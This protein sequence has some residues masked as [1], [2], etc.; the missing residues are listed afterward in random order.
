MKTLTTSLLDVNVYKNNI[1]N[2]AENISDSAKV[3]WSGLSPNTDYWW[4]ASI[5]S[6]DGDR[7]NTELAEV[8]TRSGGGHSSQDKNETAPPVSKPDPS[9]IVIS[10]GSEI[11]SVT[12]EM[13]GT[14]TVSTL[15]LDQAKMTKMLE[16]M[17]DSSL[18][19]LQFQ[20]SPGVAKGLLS[21]QTMKELADKSAN[22][23][24]SAGS[25]N[26]LIPTAYLNV[27]EVKNQL[28]TEVRSEDL[29]FSI[30]I[31]SGTAESSEEV[32]REAR[33]HDYKL[34][35]EPV[36]FEITC[37]ANC[38]SVDIVHF[39]GYIQR[40]IPLSP[41]DAASGHITG[42]VLNSDGT[43]SHV[44]TEVKEIDGVWYAV[45]SSMTNSTYA[46]IS[47]SIDFKD[48]A[49]HWAKSNA[50][51]MGER[52]ILTGRGENIFDPDAD[53]SRSEFVA[54]VV[55]ALGLLRTGTG[56]P[57]FS[58][59]SENSWYYDAASTAYRSEILTGDD[60]GRFNAGNS[61]SREEAMTII[62]RAMTLTGLDPSLGKE[63]A[64]NILS[65]FHDYG[66]AS[67]WAKAGMAACIKTGVIKGDQ[68]LMLS[69]KDNISSAE[70]A[71]ILKRLLKSSDLI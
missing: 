1:I 21:G 43:F 69:P 54:A 10:D 9:G 26:Y 42:V 59:V 15:T 24:I 6:P 60:K 45:I 8:H 20:G 63:D 34:L 11:A 7:F 40:S 44:P 16:G 23:Q 49:N 55:R 4:Y 38:K 53:M 58:D 2:T 33:Q 37:T 36:S 31:Y 35:S 56:E 64:E 47:T 3:S 41:E 29:Q 67:Q 66:K 19:T 57:A 50:E 48:M 39:S 61:I 25:V 28:G 27:D 14:Q 22:L 5:I 17:K 18:V 12:T 62:A 52:L 51:E 46:V 71:V 65:K 32:K 13:K 68:N 30:S 70:V